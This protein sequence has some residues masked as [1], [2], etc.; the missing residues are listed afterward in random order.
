MWKDFFY[1]S[2]G[3]R[4][5]IILLLLLI[6]L[7]IAIDTFLPRFYHE[8]ENKDT[9]FLIEVSDFRKS[10]VK[11][12]SLRK[13]AWDEKYKFEYSPKAFS[14][15]NKTESYTLFEFNP[16]VIDSTQFVRLG[17]KP[18]IAHNILKF[19]VKG[20]V[21]RT[22]AAFAKVYGITPEKFKELEPYIQLPEIVEYK[23]DSV[24]LAN[25]SKWAN[26]KVELNSADTTELIQ[27]KGI[28][29]F[30]AKSI[31]RFR[32]QTGG[33]VS[34][35]QL[36]ELYGMTELNFEKIKTFCTVNKNLV[37]RIRV[38]TATVERLKSHP[39]LNFYQAK[40]IYELR[41]NKG[42]LR[43]IKEL[44]VIEELSP[45]NLLKI[46]PYLSFE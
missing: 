8:E 45:E 42:K 39:Y 10:L 27:V 41:R 21:F 2:R 29:R 11:R 28:G 37:Q 24:K 9:G 35:D 31:I 12:D 17:L 15:N 23:K 36:H 1:F 26:L 13:L 5:G 22:K 4:S 40:A 14:Y 44:N 32:Q 30:Y 7:S 3:Q 19:R 34:V 18:F 38:N 20:G 16:N 6:A 33:F 46:E 43:S 25:E